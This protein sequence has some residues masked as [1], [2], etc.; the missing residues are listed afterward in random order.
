MFEVKITIAAPELAAAINNLA[1]AIGGTKTQ[2]TTNSTVPP[3]V[4]PANHTAPNV[5]FAGGAPV[6]APVSQPSVSSTAPVINSVPAS[7]AAPTPPT[8][9]FNPATSVAAPCVPLAQPPKYTVDQIMAAGAAL[10]DAGRVNDLMNL[11]H[12]FGVQAVTD[13]KQEQLGAFATAMRDMGA[14][15]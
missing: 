5:S 13:L 7:M 4:T 9:S 11:L 10:M 3:M 15:I 12:S 2:P 14:K 1:V 8:I 6:V